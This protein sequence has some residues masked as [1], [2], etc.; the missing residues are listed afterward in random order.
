MFEDMSSDELI[1][2]Y[3]KNAREIKASQGCVDGIDNS[4]VARDF[5]GSDRRS[6]EAR[7]ECLTEDNAMIAEILSE[8][9]INVEDK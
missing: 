5:D 1:R 6:Q 3:Q 2:E 4:W 7:I 9:G 8:R